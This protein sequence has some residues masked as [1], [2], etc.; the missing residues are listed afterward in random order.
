MKIL[1]SSKTVAAHD[2]REIAR[3]IKNS[4]HTSKTKKRRISIWN[5]LADDRIHDVMV[6]SLKVTCEGIIERSV[7]LL[8]V[9]LD[10]EA[11]S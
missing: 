1:Q 6:V 4:I 3:M 8:T 11:V 9:S 10:V 2:R 5:S 7:N